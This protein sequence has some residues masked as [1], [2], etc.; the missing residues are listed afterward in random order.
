MP[1]KDSLI[2]ATAVVHG[3]ESYSR[4]GRTGFLACFAASAAISSNAAM[5]AFLKVDGSA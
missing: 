1:V 5:C 4:N 3:C 2:V